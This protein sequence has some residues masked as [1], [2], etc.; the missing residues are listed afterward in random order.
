[1]WRAAVSIIQAWILA[2][3]FWFME[4]S[5]SV[6]HPWE[7]RIVTRLGNHFEHPFVSRGET[8]CNQI[9][10]FGQW[11][12]AIPVV[13][14][15]ARAARW[16]ATGK[17]LLPPVAWKVVFGVA[18]VLALVMNMNAF[19]Y[20]VPVVALEWVVATRENVAHG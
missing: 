11:A 19:V 20:I 7:K 17:N 5:V 12:I 1:M 6:H 14:L 9:C 18:L 16:R 10:A 8:S 2:Y 3:T 15:V 13:L 4:T